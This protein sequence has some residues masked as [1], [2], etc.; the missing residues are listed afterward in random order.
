MRGISIIIIEEDSSFTQRCLDS[1]DRK[2]DVDLE[3]IIL[4]IKE[5]SF[6]LEN[7]NI[8]YFETNDSSKSL[9][10]VIHSALGDYLFIIKST[11]VLDKNI[12]T[13]TRVK[14]DTIYAFTILHKEGDLL[15]E[16][17]E[18]STLIYA[19]L[20]PKE[21]ILSEN[22]VIK[23]LT[24]EEQLRFFI[25][26]RIL[27]IEIVKSCDEY[28]YANKEDNVWELS[29]EFTKYMVEQYKKLSGVCFKFE[30][31]QYSKIWLTDD[32]E[33]MEFILDIYPLISKSLQEN[34]ELAKIY[35]LPIF[36]KFV[37]DTNDEKIYMLLKK[38]IFLIN[39]KVYAECIY[40]LLE[41]DSLT[42]KLFL[43]AEY[44]DFRYYLQNLQKAAIKN[45]LSD[46]TTTTEK[47][48]K[49]ICNKIS[50]RD[51]EGNELIE[52][53]LNCY[54]NG[55]LGFQIIIKS[56]EQWLKYKLQKKNSGRK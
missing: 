24:L 45:K 9:S 29:S 30:L 47:E 36:Q 28:V 51:L 2:L 42:V 1:I 10:Q 13:D 33:K 25:E 40:Q 6:V 26:L 4:G 44:L 35:V 3:I 52:F 12:L 38:Y 39:Q 20:I 32:E 17:E 21:L 27:G 41:M 50:N 7:A 46:K 37:F 11:Y 43:S 56:G 14:K 18:D 34:V 53:T 49:K 5:K 55:K 54:G 19:K 31:L 15:Q 23:N 16:Y 22:L 48:H 8:T